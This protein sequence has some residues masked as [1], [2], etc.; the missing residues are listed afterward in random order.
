MGEQDATGVTITE[1]VPVDTVFLPASSSPGWACD[2]DLSAGSTCT[3]DIGDL[4]GGESGTATFTV[5]LLSDADEATIPNTITIADDGANGPDANPDDN[6]DT[7]LDQLAGPGDLNKILADTN[8]DFTTGTE[9]AIGELLTYQITINVHPGNMTGL[10]LTDVLDQ[11]LAFVDCDSIT[12]SVEV[13]TDLVGGFDAACDPDTNPTVTDLSAAPVDAG[14]QLT[15]SLGEVSNATGET[16]TLTIR[17]TVAVLDAAEVQRGGLLANGATLTWTGGTL[18]D[19]S[20]AV[21]VIEPTLTLHQGRRPEDHSTRWPG[22]LHAPGGT[23]H[24]Q[25]QPGLRPCSGGHGPGGSN[26]RPRNVD[27]DLR[28]NR[29]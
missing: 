11:G 12:P 4:G 10:T 14:R 16:G 13:S 18:T 29:R 20:E 28:G 1:T 25:R 26:L 15:F 6:S 24:R 5:R 7:D 19:A 8:Q 22:D 21:T 23:R 2:P 9:A 3:L 27:R 17:Y